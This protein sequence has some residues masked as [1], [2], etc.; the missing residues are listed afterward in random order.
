M[1]SGVTGK[2]PGPGPAPKFTC[3]V[4]P[5]TNDKSQICFKNGHILKGMLSQSTIALLSGLKYR[6]DAKRET[7][8]IPLGSI[9][10]EDELPELVE[11]AKLSDAERNAVWALFAIRFKV[12]DK[13]QLS[14]EEAAFWEAARAEVP[15]W[16]LFQ[17]IELSPEDR[18]AREE[19]E[20]DVEKQFEAF[21]GHVDQVQLTDKG[22]GLQEFSVTFDLAK[23]LDPER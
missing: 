8:L 3:P 15:G 7:C 4:R 12:W 9:Y 17:R 6:P 20:Q 21:F 13:E 1:R 14:T 19:A 16:A 2:V 5:F 11:L 23:K 22:H 18:R 10:W